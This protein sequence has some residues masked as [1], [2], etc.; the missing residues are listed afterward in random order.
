MSLE[1]AQIPAST[2]TVLKFGPESRASLEARGGPSRAATPTLAAKHT[3]VP[4]AKALHR[5]IS[6]TTLIGRRARRVGYFNL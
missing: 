3:P 2:F 5:L 4:F 1:T 6:E